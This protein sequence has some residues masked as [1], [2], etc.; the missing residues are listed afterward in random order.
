MIEITQESAVWGIT[1]LAILVI[2]IITGY[3][4]I[5]YSL[6]AIVI[7]WLVTSLNQKLIPR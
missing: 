2:G 4:I 7:L 5:I 1:A 6:D 3:R